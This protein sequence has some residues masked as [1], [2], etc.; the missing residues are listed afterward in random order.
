MNS[1]TKF[2]EELGKTIDLME[3]LSKV[4]EHYRN[5]VDIV[6][7]QN[8]GISNEMLLAAGQASVGMDVN[9]VSAARTRKETLENQLAQ[10]QAAL[11]RAR[12][13]GLEEDAKQWE[14][15]IEGM[16][17]KLEEAEQDFLQSWEDALTA[18]NEQFELAISSAI[19]T[20]SDQLAG[21]LMGS[22]E[23]LQEAFERQG[24]I[25]SLYLPN[26][27]KIY[28][29][30]KLNRDILKSMDDTDS[31]KAKQEL[32]ALQAEINALEAEGV[33]V[34]KYQT[35]DLRRRYELKLAEIALTDAQNAKS[36][37]QMARG[38]DGNWSYVYTANEEDVAA[39]EQNYE[40]KLFA[41]QQANAQYINNMQSSLIQTQTELSAKIEE[42]MADET[43]SAE[44]KMARVNEITEYYVTLFNYYSGQLNL[45]LENNSQ[46]FHETALATLT[47]FQ[48]IE[49]YQQNLNNAIGDGE[50]GGMLYELAQA[51]STWQA[52]VEEAMAAAGTTTLDYANTMAEA[53]NSASEASQ[54]AA[55][56]IVED[57][58]EI[59]DAFTDIIDAVEAWEAQYSEVID[60]MLLKNQA[61][62][63]S[64]NQILQAWS[65]YTSAT[66]DDPSD[67]PT[68][69]NNNSGSETG[70]EGTEG[71]DENQGGGIGKL[72]VHRGTMNIRSGPG[73]R[74]KDIG[75]INAKDGAK[76]YNYSKK[77]GN[78]V[79]VDALNGWVHGKYKGYTSIAAFDTGGYT[80]SWGEEGRWAL[81]HQKELVLNKDD[82]ENLLNTVDM[83]RQIA[84]V[85]D[86]NAYASAGFGSSGF[87]IAKGQSGTLEQHVQITAEFPNATN[88]EEIYAAF[89]DI[90]NLASQYANR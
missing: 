13:A 30:N 52:N 20:F 23:Q 40:D 57:S 62:A 53:V 5:I 25:T 54:E 37:V 7:K 28:E 29:L 58:E 18:I 82:T 38:A 59:V 17:K 34:S 86:L 4:T 44:E 87:S 72:T 75:T 66:Q 35:E 68:T 48:T 63:E 39:A 71:S 41:I 80:G 85:I 3:H 70:G 77:N 6:G 56:Q 55:D 16:R 42:I 67:S 79:Y 36:Q 2:N 61:L 65:D 64:F 69:G 32:A 15:T 60:N 33:E 78:W 81:L 19:E 43:I 10:A 12:A 26:Y 90:V 74:Y 31:I 49:E 8:L 27:E 47:G 89:N 50:T 1:F 51:Y 73:T 11:E 83:I 84:K 46:Q 14:K 45:G 88:R 22:L 76:T 21:P 9:R 24:T